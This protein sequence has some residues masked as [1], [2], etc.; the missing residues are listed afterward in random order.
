LRLLSRASRR[1]FQSLTLALWNAHERCYGAYRFTAQECWWRRCIKGVSITWPQVIENSGLDSR[2]SVRIKT[3][4]LV[5]RSTV[6]DCLREIDWATT[7]ATLRQFSMA[8]ER[9]QNSSAASSVA[10]KRLGGILSPLRASNPRTVPRIRRCL[11][12]MNHSVVL[13]ACAE[14]Q[15]VQAR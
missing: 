13:P 2:L 7:I 14:L 10:Y 15:A 1:R 9:S 11:L 8:A 4:V 6:A 12:A 3:C 5:Q